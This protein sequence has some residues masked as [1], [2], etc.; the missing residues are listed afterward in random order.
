MRER[1]VYIT[2]RVISINTAKNIRGKVLLSVGKSKITEA[3]QS[4]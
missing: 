4:I 1:L 2:T 3:E